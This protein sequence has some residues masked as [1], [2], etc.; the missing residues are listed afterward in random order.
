[1]LGIACFGGVSAARYRLEHTVACDTHR[2]KSVGSSTEGSG[3]GGAYCG[4]W[5]CWVC[6]SAGT[7]PEADLAYLRGYRDRLRELVKTDGLA[8]PVMW[9]RSGG[10]L[11]IGTATAT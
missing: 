6:I 7:V 11:L 4:R 8:D 10:G 2:H 5:Y 3:T 9:R 1:M